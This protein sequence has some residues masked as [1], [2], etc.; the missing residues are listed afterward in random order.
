MDVVSNGDEPYKFMLYTESSLYFKDNANVS[1]SSESDYNLIRILNESQS[2]LEN[3][4]SVFIEDNASVSA[5]TTNDG[6]AV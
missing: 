2:E 5:K 3:F 4:P 6:V 1:F